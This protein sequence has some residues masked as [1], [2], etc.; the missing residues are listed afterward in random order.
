M[1]GGHAHR[2]AAQYVESVTLISNY[3]TALGKSAIRAHAE[4]VLISV[5]SSMEDSG[6]TGTVD[7]DPSGDISR[8]SALEL[9]D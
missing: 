3:I 7:H 8:S 4:T 6:G 2:E 5:T 1:M 9:P